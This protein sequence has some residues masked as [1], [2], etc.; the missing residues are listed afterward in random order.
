[1][2]NIYRT[3]I[4]RSFP[5][6]HGNISFPVKHG[7]L[8]FPE[9]NHISLINMSWYFRRINRIFPDKPKLLTTLHGKNECGRLNLGGWMGKVRL[10]A[11]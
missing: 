8:S 9:L 7:N 1:M 6:K 4:F 10:A 3:F 2:I 5:V 11:C